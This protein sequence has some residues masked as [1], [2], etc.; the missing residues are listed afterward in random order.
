MKLSIFKPLLS[1][2][3][4]SI[5]CFSA[6]YYI[7]IYLIGQDAL[8][9]FYFSV[10]QIYLFFTI[11]S[12]LII[13]TLVFVRKKNLDIVGYFYLILTMVKMGVAYFFLHQINKNPHEF[14]SYEKNS[15]F[16]S[17]ILYLAI[18]TLITIRILNKNQ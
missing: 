1:V 2:L 17:F 8:S 3:G 13:T 15:F 16:L 11:S 5:L 14:L 10:E 4:F 12:I 7:L 6:H 18:E 9:D